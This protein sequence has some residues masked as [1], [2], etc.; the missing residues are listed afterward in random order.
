MSSRRDEMCRFTP[1]D[2]EVLI[3]PDLYPAWTCSKLPRPHDSQ[4]GLLTVSDQRAADLLAPLFYSSKV[5]P[6]GQHISYVSTPLTRCLLTARCTTRIS[7]GRCYGHAGPHRMG[8]QRA[9]GRSGRGTGQKVLRNFLEYP[10]CLVI[11]IDF[12]KNRFARAIGEKIRTRG[13]RDQLKTRACLPRR[14]ARRAEPRPLPPQAQYELSRP[15]TRVRVGRPRLWSTHR[16][17]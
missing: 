13:A 9:V 4:A 2:Y 8:T 12:Q 3:H 5:S 10:P 7:P 17:V 11:N 6:V 1:A 14:V 16:P 15:S